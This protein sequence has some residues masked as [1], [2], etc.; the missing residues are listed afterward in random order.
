M[1]SFL[2]DT[3]IVRFIKRHHVFSLSTTRGN[4][5][6][7][8]SCFYVYDETEARFIFISEEDTRHIFEASIN[9]AVSGN[10][11]LETKII[12]KIQGLQFSGILKKES[13]DTIEKC[14]KIYFKKFPYALPFLGK[15]AFWSLYADYMKFTDNQL[16]FGKK[17]IWKSGG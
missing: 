10:I 7:S 17:I 6:W 14:R 9:P 11:V 5:P 1:C 3:R 2:P 13:N 12:G 8:C 4:Q 15:A 16:G